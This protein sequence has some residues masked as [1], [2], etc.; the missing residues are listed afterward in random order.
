MNE[1]EDLGTVIGWDESSEDLSAPSFEF[2]LQL[3]WAGPWEA[4]ED[5]A[6]GE[7]ISELFSE[8]ADVLSG[9]AAK[10]DDEEEEDDEYDDKEDGILS[11]GAK[12]RRLLPFASSISEYFLPN[13]PLLFRPRPEWWPTNKQ[14]NRALF[15]YQDTILHAAIRENATEAALVLIEMVAESISQTKPSG[16]Y[17]KQ[18]Y[19]SSPMLIAGNL[20]GVTPLMLASQQGNIPV[21]LALLRQPL[22]VDPAAVA[23]D[24]TTALIEA[25]RGGHVAIMELLFQFGEPWRLVSARVNDGTNALMYAAREGHLGAVECLLRHGAAVHR[26]N[27]ENMTALL[28]AAQRGHAMICQRLLDA[29]ADVDHITSRNATALSLACLSGHVG[30]VQVLVAAGCAFHVPDQNRRFRFGEGRGRRNRLEEI[31]RASRWRRDGDE[32]G[33]LSTETKQS[34]NHLLDPVVQFGM[35]QHATRKK[36]NHELMRMYTLLQQNR[37]NVNIPN[38]Y[39]SKDAVIDLEKM[40]ELYNHTPAY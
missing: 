29:G 13:G 15:K 19:T 36:R 6:W 24:G 4:I 12:R 7:T 16:R 23:P 3:P 10:V 37:A 20:V 11:D 25:A 18:L 30:V 17:T 1:N 21:V 14:Y 28:M 27:R 31:T 34:L 9:G 39:A 35:M 32:A 33:S 26:G 22:L 2:F 38:L 5:L 8:A 40:V